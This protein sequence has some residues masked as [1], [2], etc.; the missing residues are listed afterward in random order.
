MTLTCDAGMIL[1]GE[2]V[3]KS[4]LGV[5]RLT[6]DLFSLCTEE[7]AWDSSDVSGNLFIVKLLIPIGDSC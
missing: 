4:V 7:S 3:C 1:C 6:I 5:R 2:V